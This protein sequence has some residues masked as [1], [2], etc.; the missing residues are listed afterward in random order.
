ME[1]T[2]QMLL[3]VCPLIFLAALVDAIAGGGGL[4]SL[5]AY[6]LAGLPPQM[7]SG[8]NKFSSSFGTLLATIRYGRAGRILYK[9]A[10]CATLGAFPG[11]YAGAWLQRQMRPESVRL[12]MLIAIPVV[13]VLL[14]FKRDFPSISRPITRKTLVLCFVIGLACGTYD[15]FFGPGTGTILIMLFT[16]VCGM[17]MV[18]ASGCAKLVNLS[19]NTAALISFLVGGCVLLPLALPATLCSLLGGYIGANLALKKGAKFIR[20]IMLAVLALLIG[21]LALEFAGIAF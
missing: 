14:L 1:V 8:S 4:I 6:L 19:S 18:S 5:P 2:L 13:A 20:Y 11:S 15:G 12:F 17:D 16:W 21:K 10:L 9:P 3:T 7:A